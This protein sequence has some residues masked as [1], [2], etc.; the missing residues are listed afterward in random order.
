MTVAGVVTHRQRP[1]TAR[2]LTFVNLE[3]E[4]GLVNVVCSPGV[5]ARYRRVAQSAPA[6]VVR[7]R[8]ES[9]GGVVN[10]VAERIERLELA[11]VTQARNFH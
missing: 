11:A 1:E 10:V 9:A 8:L 2:G 7:G 6:M 3:D 4:S 5:W